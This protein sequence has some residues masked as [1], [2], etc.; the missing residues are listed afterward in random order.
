MQDQLSNIAEF[1]DALTSNEISQLRAAHDELMS[2][3]PEDLADLSDAL[4]AVAVDPD[5]YPALKRAATEAGDDSLPAEY[6][7]QAISIL[8]AV[9]KSAVGSMTRKPM[10]NGGIAGVHPTDTIT[11]H[12][13][14]G[15]ALLLES[16]GGAG[17]V[18]PMTGNREYFLKN[19]G[20]IFKKVGKTLKKA[21]PLILSVGA[22]A[23]LGPAGLGLSPMVAGAVGSGLS[24]LVTGGSPEDALK[25]AAIGGAVGF[26]AGK[27][28]L[29]G[30][31]TASSA[32]QGAAA[33][34]TAKGTAAAKTADTVRA[35]GPKGSTVAAPTEGGI[36][37]T[38]TDKAS[39]FFQNTLSPNRAMPTPQD[40]TG[41]E[42]FQQLR[43][44][45]IS[46]D[47]AFETVGQQMTPSAFSRYAPLAALGVGALAL[48]GGF[49][50]EEAAPT[51]NDLYMQRMQNQ[52]QQVDQML[53]A[54]PQA[55]SIF[56]AG[57]QGG[58]SMAPYQS[59][60][61]QTDTNYRI[62]FKEGGPADD[63]GFEDA[64]ASRSPAAK[65]APSGTD[66]SEGPDRSGFGGF[67]SNLADRA[68]EAFSSA[69]E[70]QVAKEKRMA[71]LAESRAAAG[72]KDR[73]LGPGGTLHRAW[74][75]FVGQPTSTP[76][77]YSSATSEGPRQ[78][79]APPPAYRPPIIPPGWTPQGYEAANPDLSQYLQQYPGAL[80]GQAREQWLQQHW[81][82]QGAQQN[83][84]FAPAEQLQSAQGLFSSLRGATG[85]LDPESSMYS[86]PYQGGL[87]SLSI[88]RTPMQAGGL[89]TSMTP[90]QSGD[91]LWE[92]IMGREYQ[93]HIQGFGKDWNT[94]K[95]SPAERAAQLARMQQSYMIQRNAM[96]PRPAAPRSAARAPSPSSSSSSASA[97][98]V[99]AGYPGGIGE[100]PGA[101]PLYPGADS[102]LPPPPQYVHQIPNVSGVP[103]SPAGA[104][105]TNALDEAQQY[106]SALNAGADPFVINAAER[107]A[108]EGVTMAGGGSPKMQLPDNNNQFRQTPVGPRING[109]VQ[110]PGT[111]TSDNIAA[112]LSPNEFVF[113]ARAVR[114]AGDGDMNRGIQAMYDLMHGFEQRA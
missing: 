103:Y 31:E 2:L 18:N 97:P 26:A 4:D 89:P 19:I 9:T 61:Y 45:G 3:P 40:I 46:A 52:Q 113:T 6:N 43:A 93:K 81:L 23:V 24:T 14:P 92:Q 15:E 20:K 38:L 85:A 100:L 63:Y 65:S 10:R 17:T 114:G 28:G 95:T 84:P 49:E 60:A 64:R 110:G 36:T 96:A 67:V 50:E 111:D 108:N 13:T 98:S 16:R 11:A 94:P 109:Q 48:T 59:P 112:A 51:A 107:V 8:N 75:E 7:P 78:Q 41:S 1:F 25:S 68:G 90:G 5:L 79:Q 86:D 27:L 71:A 91:P 47:K 101:R 99:A 21:A 70:Q 74:N 34:T 12:I 33:A 105:F 32:P 88:Q 35:L 106:Y 29:A 56:P 57:S 102:M 73:F 54:D 66:R 76:Q 58:I 53:A 39:N 30:G 62:A 44:Q 82:S 22:T 69:R 72:A 42:A 37:S 77:F 104:G 83:R 80:Q 87:A 55:F